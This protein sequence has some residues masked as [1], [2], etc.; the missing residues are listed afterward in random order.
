MTWIVVI[1]SF[2]ILIVL[3]EE[4]VYYLLRT[5]IMENQPERKKNAGKMK[6]WLHKMKLIPNNGQQNH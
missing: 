5:R 2:F 4:L 3:S 6:G 1:I